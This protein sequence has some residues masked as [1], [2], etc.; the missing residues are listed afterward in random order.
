MTIAIINFARRRAKWLAGIA[1]L[2]AVALIVVLGRTRVEGSTA[3]SPPFWTQLSTSPECG[4]C[5]DCGCDALR[6]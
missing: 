2:V 3:Y 6:A 5:S 1:A 4:D